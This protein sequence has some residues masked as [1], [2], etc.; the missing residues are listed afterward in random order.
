MEN[1][2]NLTKFMKKFAHF[3]SVLRYEAIQVICSKKN[4]AMR[5]I[6]STSRLKNNQIFRKI[7]IEIKKE[8]KKKVTLISH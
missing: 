7:I 5:E 8:K 6:P 2:V 1:S 3:A 4:S